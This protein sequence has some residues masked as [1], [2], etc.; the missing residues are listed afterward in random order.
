MVTRDTTS[1]TEAL[2]L[3]VQRGFRH[4]VRSLVLYFTLLSRLTKSFHS[5][6]ATRMAT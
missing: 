1:A 5:R 4:L 3:M 6:F 2:Q